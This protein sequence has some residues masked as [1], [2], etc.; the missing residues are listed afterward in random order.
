M[1]RIPIP[2]LA[3][4]LA[5]VLTKMMDNAI[6]NIIELDEEPTTASEILQTNQIGKYGTNIYLNIG[7]TVLKVTATAV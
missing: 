5:S 1:E 6:G 2:N 4:D 3:P 7:G